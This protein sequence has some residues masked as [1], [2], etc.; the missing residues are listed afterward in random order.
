MDRAHATETALL[1][2]S[3]FEGASQACLDWLHRRFGLPL[4]MLTRAGS[5]RWVV[6]SAHD[7]GT[8]VGPGDSLRWSDTF[9][10]RMARG[11]GP[12]VTVDAALV[13][14]YASIMAQLPR[15][16]RTYVGFPLLRTDGQL[17][18]TLCGI[19]PEPVPAEQLAEAE[20]IVPLLA[21]TLS[22]LLDRELALQ[23]TERRAERVTVDATRDALTG[24]LNR[25][26]WDILTGNEEIRCR[27]FGNEA[28]VIMIDLDDLKPIND[29][30]GHAAG[31]AL[32]I[33]AAKVLESFSHSRA[34]VARLGG[35]EFAVLLIET[36][37]QALSVC[38][39]TMRRSFAEAGIAASVGSASRRYRGTLSAALADADANMYE[40]KRQHKAAL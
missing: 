31:D 12:H 13:P 14:A 25:R 9:C 11:E 34:H 1:P 26:G 27:R 23:E 29:R 22:T 24:L 3:D 10:D 7:V 18:G 28:G 17:F 20:L 32:L 33:R 8:G 4:W 19:D 21:R 35:D 40:E 16:I 5:E 15:P 30:L 2:F 39:E 36:P 38:A 6:L 37:R